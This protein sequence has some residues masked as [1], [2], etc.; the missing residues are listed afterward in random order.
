[1]EAHVLP[2]MGRW[3]SAAA[4]QWPDQR[5]PPLM[6]QSCCWEFICCLVLSNSHSVL[7]IHLRRLF[8]L[9]RISNCSANDSTTSD[10]SKH[11][12]RG[13]NFSQDFLELLLTPMFWQSDASITRPKQ[14]IQSWKLI[15]F[16]PSLQSESWGSVS[17]ANHGCSS[18]ERR[19]SGGWRRVRL[20]TSLRTSVASIERGQLVI[21]EGSQKVEVSGF[22]LR[23]CGCALCFFSAVQHNQ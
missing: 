16:Y 8:S 17:H 13:V 22:Y 15:F 21:T 20:L 2:Q 1:M 19:R 18:R 5:N 9:L 3:S 7:H 11:H 4:T 10:L 14:R 6:R 12:I 23:L